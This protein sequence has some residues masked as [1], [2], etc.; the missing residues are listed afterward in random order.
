MRKYG[1]AAKDRDIDLAPGRTAL[2]ELRAQRG[3]LPDGTL[4]L[5]PRR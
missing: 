2:A 1:D 5:F 3:V 4:R